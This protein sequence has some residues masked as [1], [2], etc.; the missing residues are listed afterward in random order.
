MFELDLKS[1]KPIS[2]Q[3][4][5]NIKALVVSGVMT[6]GEKL[7]SVR[8]MASELTV[9]PNT[10]QKAFKILEHQGYIYTSPGRGT[11]V[12]D[13]EEIVVTESE[14]AEVRRYLEESLN[15]MFYLGISKEKARKIIEDMLEERKD[16]K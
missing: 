16:W 4:V 7:P 9:N 6:S 14:I 1:R 2:N 5:D 8:D 13:M 11:F 3:I 10:V 15:K 12:Q